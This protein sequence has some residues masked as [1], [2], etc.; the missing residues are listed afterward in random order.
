MIASSSDELASITYLEWQELY[1]SEKPFQIFANVPPGS[2]ER[3]TNLVF[4]PSPRLAIHDIRGQESSFTLDANGF[5]V[6]RDQMPDFDLS[7][8]ESIDS[9]VLPYL[10]GLVRK[11]VDGVDFVCCFDYG[12]SPV[13]A[14]R[15]RSM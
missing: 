15:P 6:V 1:Q 3:L 7:T 11:H 4:T 8:R 5:T 9:T 14:S 12:V 2:T 10:E 13:Q